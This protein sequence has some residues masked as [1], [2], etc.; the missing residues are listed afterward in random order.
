MIEWYED[1]V[2]G[3]PVG[4]SVWT[5]LMIGACLYKIVWGIGDFRMFGSSYHVSKVWAGCAGVVLCIFML[6]PIPLVWTL[7][8]VARNWNK[9]EFD[10]MI[11][12]EQRVE[13][14]KARRG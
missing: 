11:A 14:R 9:S 1:Y 7:I 2:N 3:F 10:E 6:W 13:M 8:N 5:P 12:H 4:Y